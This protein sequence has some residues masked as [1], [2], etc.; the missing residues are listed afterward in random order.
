MEGHTLST[1]ADRVADQELA[2]STG[3]C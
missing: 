3:E 1:S 2:L